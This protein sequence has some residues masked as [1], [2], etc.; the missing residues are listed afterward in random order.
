MEPMTC[1]PSN[2]TITHMT[3]WYTS[4]RWGR[5]IFLYMGVVVGRIKNSRIRKVL[6]PPSPSFASICNGRPILLGLLNHAFDLLRAQPARVISDGDLVLLP[7]RLVLRRHVHDAI[8]VDVKGDLNLW[9]ASWRSLDPIQTK[10][11]EQVVVV[12][13]HTLAL[14]HLDEHTAL[15]VAASSEHLLF[16]GGDGGVPRD[17]QAH[18]T[19]DRPHPERERRDIDQE[20][21]LQ[22]VMTTE[23][24][25]LDGGAARDA[26][27]KINA[28][29]DLLP[30]KEFLQKVLHLGDAGGAA[31]ENDVLDAGLVHLG[32]AEAL[33]DN[34]NA[35]TKQVLVDLLEAG[36]GDGGGEVDAAMERVDLN[37]GV[38][39]V[40]QRPLC[41][42]AGSPQPPERPL[43]ASDI[44]LLVPLDELAHK[45]F[46]H[47]AVEIC[48]AKVGIAGGGLHLEDAHIHVG[49]RVDFED[50]DV[51]G[52][53]TEVEDE[54]RPL[55]V[56]ARYLVET[57]GDGGGRGLVDYAH[58]VQAGDGAGV[59]GGLALRVVEVDWDCDDGV[60]DIR[61]KVGIGGLLHL[62]EHHGGDLLRRELLLLAV[63]LHADHRP[64]VAARAMHLISSL[65]NRPLWLVIVMLFVCPVVLSLADTFR[66]PF[67]SMS[68]V[69]SIQG[70]PPGAGGMPV[71][72]N[73][74]SRLLSLVLALSP[75]YTL[76]RMLS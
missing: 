37:G 16:L 23:N 51:Q 22:I 15:V 60:L 62:G 45:V 74:P 65:P 13:A 63:I 64:V 67:V 33:L 68:K 39:A 21:I 66:M 69:T 29:A 1:G 12:R 35:L 40:R 49:A 27:V 17:H 41:P 70:T 46:H 24:G 76:K 59:H 43:V 53:P 52:A 54:H 3:Y 47:L 61:G 44:K 73:S 6:R 2:I 25:G 30:V 75:S 71:S 48:P 5:C 7:R 50:R 58:H 4:Q 20:H 34:P 26:L 14:V 8:G 36:A 19:T 56:A 9:H 32:V 38:H 28:L 31:H 72:Q 55:L 42:L 10:L 11:A 18:R 57:V